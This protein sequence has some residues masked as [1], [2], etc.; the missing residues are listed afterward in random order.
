MAI[1]WIVSIIATLIIADQKKLNVGGYFLL[2]LL[3]GPLAVLIILLVS[4]QKMKVDDSQDIR[5]QLRDL[6]NS[7][8]VLQRKVNSLE[9]L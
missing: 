8:F 2:S 1:I 3:T 4:P 5:Q 6:N 9:T 7:F